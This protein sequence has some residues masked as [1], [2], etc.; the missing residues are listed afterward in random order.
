MN[1]RTYGTDE[2]L[3]FCRDYLSRRNISSV[4]DII[5]LPIPTTRDGKTLFGLNK[6]PEEIFISALDEEA[7]NGCEKAYGSVGEGKSKANGRTSLCDKETSVRELIFPGTAF[8]GYGIPKS[9]K[10]YFSDIGGY[11]V[12]VARDGEFV[13]E[14]ASLTADG[15]LGKILTSCKR[16]PR[17]LSVG[18]IGYGRIGKRLANLFLFLGSRLSVF[19]S[20]EEIIEELCSLGV[21]AIP[22]DSLSREDSVSKLCELDLIINTAPAATIGENL[23]RALPDLKIVELASG[24]NF[25]DKK[26]VLRLPSLPAIMY[27]ESAGRIL[28]ES[29]LRMLGE[30][31]D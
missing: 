2:R 8:V 28:A 18:I 25:P 7:E 5:I 19:T 6:E 24:N 10:K 4:R 29:V 31:K 20:K 3:G 27:P 26:D 14:N 15:A 17:D 23:L 21:S 9:F 12:D 16:A 11:T 30:E 1:I 13:E 22:T